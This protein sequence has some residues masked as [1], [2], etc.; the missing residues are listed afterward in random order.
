M[1]TV[2]IAY[3]TNDEETTMLDLI[4]DSL[5]D[6]KKQMLAQV[7][8]VTEQFF[9]NKKYIDNVY[10]EE[11][12]NQLCDDCNIIQIELD[13]SEEIVFESNWF[14]IEKKDKTG[15]LSRFKVLNPEDYTID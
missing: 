2:F 14:R 3:Y 9:T 5:L 12:F 13:D 7:L 8:L 4:C 11:L 15:I 1:K 10:S 6:I